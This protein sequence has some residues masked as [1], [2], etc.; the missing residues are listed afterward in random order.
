MIFIKSSREIIQPDDEDS[1]TQKIFSEVEICKHPRKN[2]IV[3]K[4]SEIMKNDMSNLVPELKKTALLV[5]F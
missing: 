2:I 5:L 1:G 3:N 4:S